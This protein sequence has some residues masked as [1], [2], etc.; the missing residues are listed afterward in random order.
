[1]TTPMTTPFLLA[2]DAG[3]TNTEFAVYEGDEQRGRW[4]ATTK[5]ARTSD[6]YA[7]WLAQLMTLEKIDP[8]RIGDAILCTVVPECEFHLRALCRSYYRCEPLIVDE[9]TDLGIEIAV[10]RPSEVGADRLVN[11]VGAHGRYPGPLIIID[12]GTATTFDVVDGEGA[13]HGGAIAP[14]INLSLDALHMA[15]ARLPRVAVERP[16]RVI[17]TATIPAMKSGVYWGY[18]GLIEGLVARLKEEFGAPMTVVATGGLAPLFRAATPAIEHVDADLTM[19]G[20][21]EIYRR[22]RRGSR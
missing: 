11:A 20:L 6:E 18:V 16:Q 4:R 7:G 1:M 15:A 21:V 12:F 14:G 5:P 22:N 9:K 10:E 17:G 2:I 8:A 13:Y 3:N 19:R